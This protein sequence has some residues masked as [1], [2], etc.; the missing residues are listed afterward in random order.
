MSA[1]IGLD[2][3]KEER[4]TR[5]RKRVSALEIS[6]SRTKKNRTFGRV[7]EISIMSEVFSLSAE[8]ATL[9]ITHT[10]YRTSSLYHRRKSQKETLR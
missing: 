4:D 1:P 10:K 8:K 5:G 6:I 2:S 9:F 3:H 7:V